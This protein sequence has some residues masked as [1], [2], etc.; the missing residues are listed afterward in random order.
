MGE[1]GEYTLK[2][3]SVLPVVVTWWKGGNIPLFWISQ[4]HKDK[5]SA[6]ETVWGKY[7][8]L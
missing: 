1:H 6:H 2:D 8:T 4:E 5:Y 3:Y 7:L